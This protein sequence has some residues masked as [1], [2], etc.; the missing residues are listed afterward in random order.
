ME[1]L[2]ANISGR[3]FVGGYFG[4]CILT[5][6]FFWIWQGER[7]DFRRGVFLEG[8]CE[9]SMH[10]KGTCRWVVLWE[11]YFLGRCFYGLVLKSRLLYGCLH[12][13][14]CE[15]NVFKGVFWPG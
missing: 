14:F 11:G 13:D 5:S 9:R 10:G 3:V 4:G 12:E 6:N 8:I 2:G 1:R 15:E 7:G